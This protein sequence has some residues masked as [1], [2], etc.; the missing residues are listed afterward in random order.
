MTRSDN[1]SVSAGQG[2]SASIIRTGDNNV[3]RLTTTMLPDPE[4]VDIAVVLA[5]LRAAQSQLTHHYSRQ[6]ACRP[7]DRSSRRLL[8]A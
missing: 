4:S 1:R 3:A 2:I 7:A 6:W 8:T 5:E